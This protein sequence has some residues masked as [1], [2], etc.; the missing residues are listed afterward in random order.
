M[1]AILSWPQCFKVKKHRLQDVDQRQDPNP[2]PCIPIEGDYW[3]HTIAECENEMFS[4]LLIFKAV[5]IQ[6]MYQI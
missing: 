5:R 3:L 6:M 2:V 1:A 4:I